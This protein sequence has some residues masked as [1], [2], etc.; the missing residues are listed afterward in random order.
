M[1]FILTKEPVNDRMMAE[2]DGATKAGHLSTIPK[3]YEVLK[4]CPYYVAC[5]K[6]AL[7][8][9]PSAPATPARLA[10]PKG[11]VIEGMHI[12]GGIE[13]ACN[14][15]VIGHDEGPYGPDTNSFRPERWLESE[16]QT[17]LYEKYHFVFG[18]GT[19][20]CLGKDIALMEIYKG[21]LQVRL[22]QK[23]D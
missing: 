20:S 5:V 21:P 14:K 3:F 1:H 6:E 9:Y 4:H 7:R 13:V 2:V 12:P 10:P 22:R 23:L 15:W 17:A 16:E 18:H 19:R 11:L 8:L